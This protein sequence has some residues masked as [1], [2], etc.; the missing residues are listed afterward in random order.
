MPLQQFG[1]WRPDV[2]DYQST[3]S[4]NVVNVVPR[5]DGYGPFNSLA[6]LS[7]ALGATCR[8]AFVAYKTD[9]SVAVLRRPSIA[10]IS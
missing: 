6:E 8:G 10:S 3:T 1:E 5:G 7:A 4:Q 9:G 2:S